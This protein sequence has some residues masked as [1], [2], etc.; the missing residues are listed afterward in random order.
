MARSTKLPPEVQVA[1]EPK[2]F[3]SDGHIELASGG[4]IP[5]DGV[6]LC[7]GYNYSFPFLKKECGV[8][9][10]NQRVK[11]LYKHCVHVDYPSMFFIGLPFSLVP[12]T[13]FH[14]QVEFC[15]NV[16]SPRNDFVLP[17]VEDM[18]A[19]AESDLQKRSAIGWP[20]RHFH[21]MAGLQF[22]YY[23]D[24]ADLCGV[25]HLDPVYR[26]LYECAC[27]WR[28]YDVSQSKLRKFRIVNVNTFLDVT[29]DGNEE[30]FEES[31][32]AAISELM[33]AKK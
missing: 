27:K 6:L 22:A 10:T 3:L 14:F 23:D 1:D 17:S 30:A 33:A 29:G 26:A 11:P 2:A 31:N 19:D 32:G 20:A 5:A 15:S 28:A 13:T 8:E 16:L 24:L 9:V 4:K 21:K 18:L 7:T 25:P 12:F